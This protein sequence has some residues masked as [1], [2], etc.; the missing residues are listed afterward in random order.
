[1]K[2]AA[3]AQALLLASAAPARAAG[4]EG[5]GGPGDLLWPAVNLAIL[6]AA[7]VH[8]GRRPIRD[9]FAA[10]HGRIRDDLD[11]AARSLAEA[12]SRHAEWQR[13]LAELDREVQRVRERSRELAEAEREHLLAEASVA[14]D[15]IRADARLAL[16]QEVRRAREELRREAAELAL[17]LAAEKLR[18]RVSDADRSRLTDEFIETIERGGAGAARAPGA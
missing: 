17:E 15:R 6:I 10:R 5:G 14:A 1:V 7:L 16:E 3:F 9:F 4:A 18:T 11:A 8:F 13:R 12:E 2:R